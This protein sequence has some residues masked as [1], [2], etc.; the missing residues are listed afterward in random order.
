MNQL[1]FSW[2]RVVPRLLWMTTSQ[3]LNRTLIF[4][5][6]SSKMTDLHEMDQ[7]VFNKIVED[8]GMKRGGAIV[9]LEVLISFFLLDVNYAEVCR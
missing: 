9:N 2:T 1:Y 7:A 8:E 4:S 6:P 3:L 5:A